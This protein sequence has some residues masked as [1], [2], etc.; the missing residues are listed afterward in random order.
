MTGR[1][2]ARIAPE[3]AGVTRL[4]ADAGAEVWAE[5]TGQYDRALRVARLSPHTLR[6][7]G[8]TLRAWASWAQRTGRSLDPAT[9]TRA[10]IEAWLLDLADGGAKPATQVQRFVGLQSFFKW[11]V[12]T[13]YLAT[14]PFAKVRRPTLPKA[15]IP[16]PPADDVMA[17]VAACNGRDFAS[18]RDRAIVSLMWD[19]GAR[20]GEVA[21]IL[22]EDID[23]EAGEVR[24]YGKGERSRMAQFG[25][26]TAQ[27]LHAYRRA[28]RNHPHRDR[29]ERVGEHADNQRVGQPWWLV[30]VG[31][32]HR[33][34]LGGSGIR[35]AIA[36]RCREAGVPVIHPHQL[37]HRW[38]DDQYAAGV[39]EGD[40]MRRGG[41]R[42]RTMLDRYAG[43]HADRRAA[44]SAVSAVDNH[45]TARRRR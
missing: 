12:D 25:D 13:D 33:G 37:R 43:A 23:I 31:T 41:W 35:D 17:V 44:A 36:R 14:T 9:T 4:P 39:P 7:Y 34:G 26:L 42:D 22:V 21:G 28:R 27:A 38:T 11:L 32:G 3:T 1:A 16:F 2:V 10:D 6:S 24:L 8:T 19:T 29:V 5:E 15:P 45:H 20:R 18:V 30:D 40:I